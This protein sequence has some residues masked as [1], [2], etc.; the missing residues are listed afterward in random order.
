MPPGFLPEAGAKVGIEAMAGQAEATG[1]EAVGAEVAVA[2]L[3]GAETLR[4][5]IAFEPP[6]LMTGTC[7]VCNPG[8]RERASSTRMPRLTPKAR[9]A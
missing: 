8:Q 5:E 2:E 9:A 3:H 7:G 6:S 1:S 4:E